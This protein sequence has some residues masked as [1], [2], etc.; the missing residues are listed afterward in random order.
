MAEV[1][2]GLLNFHKHLRKMKTKCMLQGQ[3]HDEVSLRL[4]H[5]LGYHRTLT[6]EYTS[7]PFL[8]KS[9]LVSSCPR[10]LLETISCPFFKTRD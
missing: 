1:G 2:L 6:C 4:G 5:D 7:S 3:E 8:Q 10:K 9:S